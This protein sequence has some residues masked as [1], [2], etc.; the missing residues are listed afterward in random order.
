MTGKS[1]R[2]SGLGDAEGRDEDDARDIGVEAGTVDEAEEHEAVVEVG[3]R[4]TAA[5]T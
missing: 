2:V 3:G 5:T 4:A 1:L